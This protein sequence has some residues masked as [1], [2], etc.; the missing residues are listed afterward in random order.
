MVDSISELARSLGWKR[1]R[2]Y[3]AGGHGIFDSNRGLVCFLKPGDRIGEV[4]AQSIEIIHPLPSEV[5]HRFYNPDVDQPWI[6]RVSP[7]AP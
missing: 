4:A 1:E 6:R 7:S 5:R 3:A 2:L